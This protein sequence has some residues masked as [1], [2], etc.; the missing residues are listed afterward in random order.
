MSRLLLGR[1]AQGAL[2]TE[3]Q[4]ALT[5]SG[6][7]AGAPDGRYGRDTETAVRAFQSSA[8]TAA[9]GAV[10][11]NDWPAITGRAV[12]GVEERCL[13]F[14][15]WLEGHG[16]TRAA[17]NWDNAWITWG[18][19]GFTLKHGNLQKV[20]R[21]VHRAS[22]ACV[23]DA[24]GADAPQLLEMIDAPPARQEAWAVSISQGER[25]AEPW[26][27]NFALFGRFP[28]VQAAQRACAREEYFVPALRTAA[29]LN[30]TSELGV[31]LT[32]D[33]HVQNGGVK[34]AI[35]EALVPKR[36]GEPEQPLRE[37]LANAV[38]DASI[39]RF[40]E[41]VRSRKL[42]IARGGGHVRGIQ[43]N[44]LNWGLA[45]LEATV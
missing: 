27:T 41:D 5:S 9:T 8:G 38:A 43:V 11:D 28:E 20:I 7:D 1:G 44:L 26:H 45:P 21:A 40:R 30:L 15:S 18:V 32:F 14:T 3:I 12:P 42:T 17:G 24:F 10:S 31:A 33:I 34:R 22:P 39:P 13:Q 23:T 19:V 6:F 37:A 36:P 25:L 4:E 29:A 35:R 16:Y 2:V